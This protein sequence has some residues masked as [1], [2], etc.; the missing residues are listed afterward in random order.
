M[1][2][3]AT[4]GICSMILNIVIL[5][6]LF[7]IMVALLVAMISLGGAV[8][9]ATSGSLGSEGWELLGDL[10]VNGLGVLGTVM[11]IV[12]MVIVGIGMLFVLATIIISIVQL[13]QYSKK[14]DCKFMLDSIVKLVVDGV[15]A[16][17]CLSSVTSNQP[18][19]L[20]LGIL[21]A[22]CVVLSIV[23]LCIKAEK[24]VSE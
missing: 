13:V 6:A 11:I 18:W 15:L 3:K 23:S 1:K 19:W 14:K 21:P 8:G 5:I 9:G 24:D 22:G 20:L 17:I 2:T 16:L 10:L 12:L 4:L 7:C